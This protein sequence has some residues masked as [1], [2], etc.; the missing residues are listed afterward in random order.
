MA[1]PAESFARRIVQ[2]LQTAGH[3]AYFAGGCVRDQLMA[4]PPK[5]YDVAT[6]A[7]P[8]QVLAL[9]PRGQKVGAAFGVILLVEKHQ[10]RRLQVEVATFRTDGTYSD[11]RH[12]DAVHFTT[13]EIDAQ[14]RDFT[15]NG[16]FFDPLANNGT[17]QLHDYVGGQADI[18]SKILRA[19]GNPEARFQEDHLR[20]LRAVRFAARLDFTLDPAT[21]AAIVQSA[22]YIRTVSRERIHDELA[23]ILAHPTRAAAAQL[24]QSTHL[25]HQLW[26]SALWEQSTVEHPVG[27]L[28]RLPGDTDWIS[29]LAAL[30]ED[31]VWFPF[32]MSTHFPARLLTPA[33]VV[34]DQLR[35]AFLLSNTETVDLA[36]LLTNL[37]TLSR[38]QTCPKYTLK[39]LLAD[40]R[41]PRLEALFIHRGLAPS[42]RDAFYARLAQLRAEGVA[43]APFVTGDTLI[44]L[45]ATPGPNFK[46]WLDDLYDRQLEG[47]L[48]TPAQALAV[49]QQ[50]IASPLN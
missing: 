50:L 33:A 38:W 41:W 30:Y 24:L 9:F 35:N 7:T 29:A 39:H 11:G 16:L 31:L 25:L 49:A 22:P 2:R 27:V 18:Q 10:G 45:G 32:I 4:R 5:D 37:T 42:L 13:A 19:I 17:G 8:D 40:S 15:C 3:V 21:H 1:H 12:P 28:R 43:P 34:A 36:W 47:E 48:Q 26:P 46:R 23:L 6:S 44:Q 14:R 20:M